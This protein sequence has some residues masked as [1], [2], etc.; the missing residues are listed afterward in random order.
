MTQWGF[1]GFVVATILS[2]V[3]THLILYRHRVVIYG[4]DLSM[5]CQTDDVDGGVQEEEQE[6]AKQTLSTTSK[7]PKLMIMILVCAAT[8]LVIAGCTIDI[9]EVINEKSGETRSTFY[10]VL[11]VGSGVPDSTLDPNAFL[12]RWIQAMFFLLGFVLPLWS[13]VLFA[14]LYLVPMTIKWHKRVFMLSEI[15]FA[16]SSIEVLMISCIFSV[17]QIPGFGNGLIQSG[18]EQCYKVDSSLYPQF[19]V[20]AV[21]AA[22]NVAVCVWL[23]RRAH[24]T[25]YPKNA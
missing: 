13:A 20:L 10:S 12:V 22:L 19:A 2:L 6:P 4:D 21:A 25:L 15:T 9:F 11:R 7:T 1:Y 18:C 5:P 3:G 14:I 24:G 16:W 23:Y 17:L 8:A